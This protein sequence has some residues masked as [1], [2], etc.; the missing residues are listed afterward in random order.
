MNR[1]NLRRA[2]LVM[3]AMETSIRT[4][5]LDGLD[6][7]RRTEVEATMLDV[8]SRGWNTRA[9]ALQQ[10]ALI[11]T[12]VPATA[13]EETVPAVFSLADH[14]QPAEFARVL[15][16]AG[17]QEQDFLLSML[18]QPMAYRVREEMALLLPMPGPVREATLAA[19]DQ[20]LSDLQKAG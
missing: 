18:E 2:A 14:L 8:V 10:L 15:Q 12:S 7:M 17:L 6:P 16:A 4:Q 9:L 19:A 20:M 1:V 3:S 5:I 11:D 13:V